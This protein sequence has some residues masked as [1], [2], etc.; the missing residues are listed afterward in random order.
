M[1][2]LHGCPSAWPVCSEQPSW[3][4]TFSTSVGAAHRA[5][6][7]TIARLK[8]AR[9]GMLE[10]DRQGKSVGWDLDGRHWHWH[11]ALGAV[12]GTGRGLWEETRRRH[13]LLLAVWRRMKATS[14]GVGLARL[15]CHFRNKSLGLF[16]FE[17]CSGAKLGVGS[18]GKERES[19]RATHTIR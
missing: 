8:E 6:V 14:W 11:W 9:N 1:L 15:A 12:E 13:A 4:A 19:P 17:I 10:C 3:L 2:T 16:R 7:C 5:C 18:F